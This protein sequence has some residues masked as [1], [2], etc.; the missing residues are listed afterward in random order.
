M[1]KQAPFKPTDIGGC[2]LWLDGADS[3]KITLTSGSNIST[4]IDKSSL[5]NN[6]TNTNTT[7]PTKTITPGGF[8]CVY[9][10]GSTCQ[11]TSVSNNSTTGNSSRTVIMIS[12]TGAGGDSRFGTGPHG[13]ASPPNTYGIDLAPVANIIFCPYVYTGSDVTAYG[14]PNTNMYSLYSYYDSST[15]TVGG[16]VNFTLTASNSTTLNTSA[17]PWYLGLRPDGG[18]S[19][20]AYVCEIIHYNSILTT[21]QR[22]QIES[23]L[24]Q[25]WG[26]R[27][28]LPQGHPGTRGI[29]YP[30]QP[31]PTAIYWR[32]PGPFIPTS[33][34]G[35]QLWLDGVDP[36]GTGTSPS[37][38]ATVSTWVDKA[39]AKNATATGTSTYLT[40]GGI[41]FTGSSYFLNQTFSQNLSQRS[42]FI[43]FQETTNSQ[44]AG[45]FPIIPTPNSGNDQSETNGLSS[46]TTNNTL[47]FVGISY[48]SSVGSGNPLPK[49]IYYDS[50]NGTIGS[51]YFNG[52]NATN[53]TAGY[54][55]GTC[56]GYG[57]GGRWQGGSMSG[58]YRLNGVIYEILFFNTSLNTLNR[59]TIEGYLAW[60]WGLQANL[61]ANH[62]Y[63]NASPNITNPAGISRPANV[64]PIPPITLY[65]STRIPVIMS[66][67]L[68]YLPLLTNSTDIGSTPRTV[69]TNGS[70]TYTTIANKQSAYFNNSFS[71]YLSLPYTPQTQLTLCFWLYV[72]G[73]GEY[74]AVSINNGALNPTLQVDLFGNSTTTTIFTAMPNQWANQPTGN[75]GGPGQ[76]AHFAITLN[77]STY[78]EQLYI[79]GTSVA[80]ATGSGSPS[81]TQSQIWLGRSGDNG[82]AYDGYIRQFC[83]FPSVLTQAQIQSIITFTT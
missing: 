54:T 48:F 75:Y 17:T 22:Q 41:N 59:Q 65:A 10:N 73:S 40:G 69:T 28:Q 36:A 11:M 23:Y 19:I 15:S 37:N 74:T 78:F 62:P 42:I 63:K 55:A 81:I 45:V 18:F 60:K 72:L 44:Y 25:K 70:V 43:V 2:Q 67:A 16:I 12:Q 35:C 82:R 51:G 24:A 50:M 1:I 20:A 8:P 49:A 4:W 14:V 53:V 6:F 47:S 57:L 13:G 77:Y 26:L 38:G 71:N 64:L 21:P 58:S 27:Q 46:E 56:S 9:L 66:T 52:T 76:W 7:A 5:A 31:I 80:T 29:V 61:P 68:S 39:T 34:S 83:T 79:N 33:I 32:Y 30:S 3:T